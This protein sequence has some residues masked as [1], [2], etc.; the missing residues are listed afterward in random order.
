MAGNQGRIPVEFARLPEFWGFWN[1]GNSRLVAAV[2]SRSAGSQL[3]S[4]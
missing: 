2:G 1:S 3:F 4:W